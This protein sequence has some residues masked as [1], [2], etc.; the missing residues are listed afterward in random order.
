MLAAGLDGI[1]REL[2]IPEAT[3]EN[4]YLLQSQTKASLSILPGSLN[5]ALN[6][7]EQDEVIREALGVHTFERFLSGKRLEWEDYRMDVSPWELNEYLS[8]Y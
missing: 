2:P 1:R 3:D 6:A 4:I 5:Q 7:L 8:K